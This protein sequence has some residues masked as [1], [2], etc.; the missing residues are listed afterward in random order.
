MPVSQT[1]KLRVLYF[2]HGH[3][4]LR[5][6][7]AEGYAH[8]LYKAMRERSDVEPV[9]VARRWPGGPPPHSGTTFTL[10]G[11]DSGEY[12]V[13]SDQYQFD[14][15]CGTITDKDFY[16]KHIQNFLRALQPDVVH[17]Q[18][19]QFLGYDL[20]RA[21]RNALPNAGIVYTLHEFLPIC[22]RDGQMVRTVDEKPCREAS[23]QRCNE[24]FPWLAPQTFF[25]RRKFIQSQL[26]LVDLFIAPSRFLLERYVEWGLPEEKMRYEDN[27]RL[28]PARVATAKSRPFRDRFAFFGQLSP[29][30]GVDVL[31]NAM[32][33]V[34]NESSKLKPGVAPY[35][36]IHGASLDLQ[37]GEFQQHLQSMLD[38]STNLSMVGRYEHDALPDLMESIDWVVVPSI[39]WENSPLVIQEA[40]IHRR[41]V[42][43]ADIG[44]MAEKVTDGV[45]GLHFRAGDAQSLAETMRTAAQTPGLWAKLRAGIPKVGSMDE[46]AGRLREIYAGLAKGTAA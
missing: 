4:N 2:V 34:A 26:A 6:G 43:C 35:L 8:E 1:R 18:H 39:W 33:I 29:Y 42:I 40:F 25:L 28:L 5:P 38:R 7:G 46:H 10:V 12:Y 45:N 32:A 23:P 36:W 17:I 30:K 11:K 44:G 14:W 15:V 9:L 22:H 20:V 16:S 37:R 27:G 19:S 13:H 41:P 31:V 3:P 24:C 21:V